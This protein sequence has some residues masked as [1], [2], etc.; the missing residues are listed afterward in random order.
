MNI[1]SLTP[2]TPASLS[3]WSD[4]SA[5]QKQM[6]EAVQAMSGMADSVGLARHILSY[7]GDRRKRALARAMAAALAGDESAAKAEAEARASDPYAK[8]LAVLGKEHQA[9]ET[10]ITDWECA[11]LRWET[12]RSLLA[13]QREGIR[14]L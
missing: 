10:Q 3:D 2:P 11:K 6:I 5:L 14:H 7:D 8:E 1:S 4:V 12:A 13:A 9:A